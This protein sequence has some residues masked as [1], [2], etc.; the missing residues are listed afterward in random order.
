MKIKKC[1]FVQKFYF[2]RILFDYY[3]CVRAFKYREFAADPELIVKCIHNN[4][5]IISI[6]ILDL[7]FS[8]RE[9][10]ITSFFIIESFK[11]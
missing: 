10:V 9:H 1:V 3:A 7:F 8:S 6:M 4:S 2:L 11:L 5:G